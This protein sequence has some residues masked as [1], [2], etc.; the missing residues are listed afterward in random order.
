MNA[1]NSASGGTGKKTNWLAIVL[2]VIVVCLCVVIIGGGGYFLLRD[3]GADLDVPAAP[4]QTST[5]ENTPQPSHTFT[6]VD[7][8]TPLPT[9]TSTPTVVPNQSLTTIAD[10]MIGLVENVGVQEAAAYDKTK[11]GPH[12][13][14]LLTQEGKLYENYFDLLPDEWKPANVSETEL[15]A[16]ITFQQAV[17][18]TQR[19]RDREGNLYTFRR[20]REDFYI[21]LK[22]AKTGRIVSEKLF[23]GQPPPHFPQTKYTDKDYY[24]NPPKIEE[25]QDWLSTFVNP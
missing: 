19:Y 12:P 18:S 17:Q 20:I 10:A 7:T 25:I 3:R 14:L 9:E 22:E 1:Q 11:Q 16:M 4:P 13:M 8:A 6:P 24:G 2:G 23:L 21:R 15:V 5:P